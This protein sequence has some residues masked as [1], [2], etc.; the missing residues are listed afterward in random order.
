MLLA[1]IRYASASNMERLIIGCTGVHQPRF[2]HSRDIIIIFTTSHISAMSGSVLSSL[3][4]IQIFLYGDILRDL[5]FTFPSHWH[6]GIYY[7]SHVCDRRDVYI[8][9]GNIVLRVILWRG[10]LRHTSL[11]KPMSNCE[12]SA[13]EPPDITSSFACRNTTLYINNQRRRMSVQF[14]EL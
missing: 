2:R 11:T 4:L 1:C 7:F 5:C 9:L 13:L 14:L 3:F 8:L 12:M 6:H 10:A